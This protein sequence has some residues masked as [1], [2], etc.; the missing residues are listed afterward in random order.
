MILDDSHDH[1]P[2]ERFRMIDTSNCTPTT[3]QTTGEYPCCLAK[4]F[5]TGNKAK[6]G[7]DDNKPAIKTLFEP[8]RSCIFAKKKTWNMPFNIPRAERSFPIVGGARPRPPI[9]IGVERKRG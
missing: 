5:I 1:I 9:S 6:E 2:N 7:I 4:T 3:I 8:H